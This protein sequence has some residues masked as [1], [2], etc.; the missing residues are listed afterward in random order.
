MT[1]SLKLL[2]TRNVY[3]KCNPWLLRHSAEVHLRVH[4]GSADGASRQQESSRLNWASMS[5]SYPQGLES[6][7][8]RSQKL[9]SY[10][11]LG[12]CIS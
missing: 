11:Q 7:V 1:Y 5:A 6:P 12:N 10:V 3:R 9:E 2:P 8:G 4:F